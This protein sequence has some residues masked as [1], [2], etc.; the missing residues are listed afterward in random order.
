LKTA[1]PEILAEAEK[2]LQRAAEEQR[3]GDFESPAAPGA[4]S[5]STKYK[6][7]RQAEASG[8][9]ALA[10]SAETIY[11]KE[12]TTIGKAQ[13]ELA[14]QIRRLAEESSLLWWVFNEYSPLLD[15]GAGSLTAPAYAL[16]AGAEAAQR[17]HIL[18]PPQSA[19]AL[20]HRALKPCKPGTKKAVPLIDF[21]TITEDG[22]RKQL[23]KD[24]DFG[25]CGGLLPMATALA[26]FDELGDGA[27]TA[28]VLSKLCPG[29]APERSYAPGDTAY[30][31]YNEL[32]FL[33]A[34]TTLTENK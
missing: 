24:I 21:I 30:Q 15:R 10:S 12:I 19:S 25:D 14:G 1:R 32:M 3:P 20:L 6:A 27:A 11:H 4:A 26:K 29:I 13:G 2:Y 18:P 33:K 16:V 28:K 31:F 23:L 34:L 22:W 17:T 5:L 7:L 9:A 8:D